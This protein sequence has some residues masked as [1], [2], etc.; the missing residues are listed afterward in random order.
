MAVAAVFSFR[1]C[2]RFAE[3]RFVAVAAVAV[4]V[5]G[6]RLFAPAS[7]LESLIRQTKGLWSS[8]GGP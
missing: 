4:V 2:P 7:H 3:L 5:F 6:W 1:K 8:A